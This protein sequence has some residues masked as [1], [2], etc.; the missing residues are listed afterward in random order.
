[1]TAVFYFSGTGHSKAVA[2][3]F[4]Q[5]LECPAESIENAA[6]A[7]YSTAAVV[8]PVYSDNIPEPVKAFLARLDSRHIALAATFGRMSHGNVLSQAA[9]LCRGQIICGAYIPTGHTYLGQTAEFDR[10]ALEPVIRRILSPV[11]AVLPAERQSTAGRI[12]PEARARLLT[13]IHRGSSCTGCGTCDR[14][15]PMGTMRCG[16]PGRD[17]LRCLRCVQSCPRNALE[18]RYSPLLRMYLRRERASGTKIYL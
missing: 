10:D 12:F 2:E 9:R 17:C 18:A 3:Y 11:P 1:M 16:L 4:S 8:F 14:V 15:C 6:D 13:K 7:Q 5:R